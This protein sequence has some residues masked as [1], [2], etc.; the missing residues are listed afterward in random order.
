MWPSDEVQWM[1]DR[2][3]QLDD[4]AFPQQFAPIAGRL[5]KNSLSLVG[6]PRFALFDWDFDCWN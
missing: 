2:F 4:S 1:V 3:S 5:P 6:G